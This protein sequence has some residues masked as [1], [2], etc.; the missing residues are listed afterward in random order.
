MAALSRAQALGHASFHIENIS[1]RR[2]RNA[3][4]SVIIR[5]NARDLPFLTL[6]QNGY[7]PLSS[8]VN[9]ERFRRPS[10]AS[11]RKNV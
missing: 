2:K 8:A 3:I 1:A 6:A 7:S 10:S 5:S 11:Q 4:I 9:F